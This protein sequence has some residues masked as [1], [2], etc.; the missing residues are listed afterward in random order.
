MVKE[1]HVKK[2][3]PAENRVFGLVFWL[4]SKEGICLRGVVSYEVAQV[5]VLAPLP[6]VV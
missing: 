5:V 1:E 4:V 2:V 6:K 3:S